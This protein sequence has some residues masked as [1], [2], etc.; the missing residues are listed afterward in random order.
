MNPSHRH[1][2][3]SSVNS[4]DAESHNGTPDTKL[5][6]LSPEEVQL[7]NSSTTRVAPTSNEPPTFSL[8]TVPAFTAIGTD[9]TT[10][11]YHDPFVTSSSGP[12]GTRRS[13][14]PKLS[15]IAPT[16]T[17]LGFNGN[18]GGIIV[19]QAVGAPVNSNRST[20]LYTPGSVPSASM[21]P[22]LAYDQA[23]R[24][25][26]LTS[27]T[28]TS[29]FHSQPTSPGSIASPS[30][31]RQP[32][33]SGRFTSDSSI[34][35][36][37]MISQVDRSTLPADLET[38]ISP[39]KFLSRKD[40]VLDNLSLNGTVYVTFTDIRDAVEAV[41]SLNKLRENWLVQY[42][43]LPPRGLHF[44]E[45]NGINSIT[46]KYEGQLLVKAHFSGPSSFFDLDTVSRLILDLLNNYG[47]LKAYYAIITVYP[48]VAYRAEFFDTKDAEHAIIHLNGFRIAPPP[49]DEFGGHLYCLADTRTTLPYLFTVSHTE[50]K[51]Q[52][53]TGS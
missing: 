3:S 37:V 49:T 18:N 26:Y 11:G 50:P 42:L 4:A 53:D 29:V 35:R 36:R 27:S 40:L 28:G 15:P 10:T 21:V 22:E 12:A 46:S 41:T 14:P 5:T 48:V 7:K 52:R 30:T 1:G 8:S 13:E 24:E 45:A 51:F 43:P 25:T 20:Y 16:F 9:S 44:Q 2:L 47:G 23:S 31:E 38:V 32:P 33:G 34:A 19:S 39:K 17:P 6:A